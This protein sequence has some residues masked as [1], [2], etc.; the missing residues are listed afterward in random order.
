MIDY[1]DTEQLVLG[2]SLFGG[3]DTGFN[4]TQTQR[5]GNYVVDLL[6]NPSKPLVG[7]NTDISL[8]ITS[9][10]GDE[11]IE[12][13]VAVYILKDGESIYSNP[14]NYT[15]VRQGHFDFS[16][17]F[18]E[19]GQYLLFIDVKDIFYTLGV[20]NFLFEVDVGLSITERI[21]ELLKNY[22]YVFI[23]LILLSFIIGILKVKQAREIKV[24]R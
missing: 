13:P 4:G 14:D 1:Q 2:H 24:K 21:V 19:A 11:L 12:L 5:I 16:H 18:D 23:P 7:T 3:S 17:V 15:F 6:L 20:I 8:R 9:S 10:T 22:Y